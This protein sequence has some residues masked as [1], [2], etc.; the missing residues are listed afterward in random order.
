MNLDDVRLFNF[1]I[2]SIICVFAGILVRELRPQLPLIE[3]V[4][5]SAM[6]I[7]IIAIIVFYKGFK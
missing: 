6:L 2:W 3:I 1:Q 5:V 4:F 7:A